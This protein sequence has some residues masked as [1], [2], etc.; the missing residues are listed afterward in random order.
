[1]YRSFVNEDTLAKSSLQLLYVQEPFDVLI[2]L[3][4]R[5]ACR[6][7]EVGQLRPAS[8]LRVPARPIVV[9]EH[10]L[11]IWAL[12]AKVGNRGAAPADDPRAAA[13]S[14]RL[15]VPAVNAREPLVAGVGLA[16]VRVSILPSVS[17]W[18]P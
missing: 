2:L 11:F 14:A 6:R 8:I 3:Q 16:D 7:L 13:E 1:M 10:E 18:S 15:L 4:A 12:D 17:N 5:T 9:A